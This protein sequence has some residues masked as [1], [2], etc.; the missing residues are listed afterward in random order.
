MSIDIKRTLTLS[1]IM[2][3]SAVQ[4][5]LAQDDNSVRGVIK[6][7]SGEP[8]VGASV[9]I[10]N[11]KIGVATDI[12]GKYSIAAPK[13]GASYTLV[14]Q[15][16]GMTT[17]EIVVDK[18]RVLDVVLLQDNQLEGSMIVGAYGTR[19]TREDLVGSAFQVNSDQLKDKPKTRVE[20][21]LA[22]LVPGLT[23]EPNI[24]QAV[25]TRTRYYT[26]L[27]GDASLSA[28][29]EPLWII[30][31]V[32]FNTG[33]STNQMLGTSYTVGPLSYIDPND[34][35]SI[36]VLK[37]A[38]QTTIYGSNGS[39]GVILITTKSGRREQPLRVSS[40][41]N[42]G[43]SSVDKSTMF[44][45]MNAEQYME[46]AK[47]AWANAGNKMELFPYQDNDMNKYSETSVF[48]PDLYL[49]MGNTEYV[50]LS[51]T[52][53]TKKTS[54]MFNLGYYREQNTVK[55]DSQQRFSFRSRNQYE[56]TDWFELDAS[57]SASFNINDLFVLNK[58]FLETVPVIS[59]Y[60]E[61]GSYRLFYKYIDAGEWKVKKF[62]DNAI[63]SREE[64][65]NIQRSLL[66]GVN[67]TAKFK[68]IKGLDFTSQFSADY[69]HSREDIYWSRMT[70]EGIDSNFEPL[71][72]SRRADASYMNWTFVNRFNFN[73]K[74]GHH[75]VSAIAGIEL[76]DQYT[77]TLYATASGFMNDNIKEITYADKSTLSANSSTRYTRRMSYLARAQYSYKSRYYLTANYRRDGNSSFGKYAKWSNFWSVGASWNVHNEDFFRSDKISMLKLKLSYGYTGNS[78]IDTSVAKGS[79]VFS[80]SFSYGT[81][82]GAVI[83]SVPNPGLSWET[84]RMINAG[85]RLELRKIG[86]VEVECYH[87]YTSDLLSRIYVSRS[88]SADRVYANIGELSNKGVE[89][90]LTSYNF[91]RPD[92]SWTTTL[93]L[94]HNS[95]RIE[96]LYNGMTTSFGQTLW[97]EGYSSD[98]YYLVRWAGVDPADGTAMWYDKDGN[99]TKTYDA[100]NRIADKN[101]RP[102]VSGGLVNNLKYGN[103]S[104]SFQINYNI[105][106][107]ALGGYASVYI[108]DG[109]DIIGGNQAIEVY[110]YRWT[111]PGVAA[112]IPKVSNVSTKSTMYSTRYLYNKTYFDLSNLTL[113]YAFDKGISLSLMCDNLY[114]FTPDQKRDV[115]SYK[116]IMN[117]Y[118]RTRSF[119]L[120][121]NCSF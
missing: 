5:L 111:T 85:V 8:L 68:I 53:G 90:S 40:T 22:G 45:M 32:P 48:W 54:N 92:F 21:L 95:N 42:F 59:P 76:Y 25:S 91:S 43:L 121:L 82:P 115:N 73:R 7:E 27:R 83:G 12:D 104:L 34:I 103:W 24:D 41:V 20:T 110:K 2:L 61:D 55:G 114:L 36:T 38:D 102:V 70:V 119:T 44:K 80:D 10:K 97:R 18:A 58:E 64:N 60:N 118:P 31:G 63:P 106:G 117:G 94:S 116:T 30:D 1:A 23:I 96:M 81:S 78:R 112:A 26:R 16:I 86:A 72:T 99:I 29:N 51:M 87:N 120:G 77:K 88:I 101:S 84:T 19:Q 11:T 35:E 93:N 37:D 109:Y 9:Y 17:K 46:V 107:W 71:G 74:F 69:L 79:Y 39:N 49:G 89:L 105:G 13:Q 98:T 56:F 66:A 108:D 33:T 62:F 3:L 50:N 67:L 57:M 52:S 100:T 28:S 65:D 15:F 113:S 4:L 6:D 75:S 47:E 14:F